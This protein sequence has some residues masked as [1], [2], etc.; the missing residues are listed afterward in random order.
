M[1]KI[2]ENEN[3]SLLD[4][5]GDSQLSFDSAKNSIDIIKAEFIEAETISWEKLFEGFDKLYAITYSSSIDFICKLV[6]KFKKAEIIFG[7]S[8]VISDHVHEV[9]AFQRIT[10]DW[11]RNEISEKGL[12]LLSRIDDGSLRMLVL[13]EYLSHEKIYI[14]E[15]EDGRKR[16]IMGSANMS[17]LAFSGRQRENICYMDGDKAFEWYYNNFEELRE[18]SSDEISTK[19]LLVSDN[20]ENIEEIPIAQTIKVKKAILLEHQNET[21]NEIR[22]TLEVKNLSPIYKQYSHK[23]DKN[24]KIMLVPDFFKQIKRKLIDAKNHEKKVRKEY[25]HFVVDIEERTAT[26]NGQQFDL[27]PNREDVKHDVILFLEYMNGYEKFHGD[28]EAM[29]TRY[30][31]FA[32]WFFTTPF[33]PFMRNMA[34]LN[35]YPPTTYPIFG[36][37]Y[38]K[39]NA[40][41]TKFLE[42]LRKMM[43]G[44]DMPIIK[45]T[46]FT[47]AKIISLAH[48]VKGAPLIVDDLNQNRFREYAIEAIK[49]SDYFGIDDGLT[50]YPAVAISGNEDIKALNPE[51]IKRAVTCRTRAG[52]PRIEAS[53]SNIVTRIQKNIGTA[54][55]REYLRCMFEKIENIIEKVQLNEYSGNPDIL[56]E[57]SKIICRI[58][59]EHN[60]G[61]L[62]FYARELTFENYFDDNIT[63]AN[64]KEAIIMAWETN[65]KN[66]IIKKKVNKL[67]YAAEDER[68]AE[69]IIK[70]LPV[71]LNAQKSHEWIIMDL[72]K[73]YEFF[74][75][76]FRRGWRIW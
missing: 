38:G 13:R 57:S 48:E 3:I 45:G 43:V 4:I 71:N 28:I 54:F 47:A 15:A 64:S 11:L 27:N 29:Q 72:D 58:I 23:P 34:E 10:G 41:K 68:D 59:N 67:R 19:V 44:Y 6:K 5:M 1:D 76:N 8:A 65:D 24:G 7:C 39:S 60:N 20:A 50:H 51:V 22:F 9:I 25:P 14:L 21:S 31:E 17:N 62:P 40:G 36:I 32:N 26:L 66:F 70:E 73:A 37:I 75:V 30:F 12:D 56:A 49:S 52:I 61:N 2:K 63:G 74:G 35:N 46:D 69:R 53:K 33:M 55:Y 18:N 16:V 42:T